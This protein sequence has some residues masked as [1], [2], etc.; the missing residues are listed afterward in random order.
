VP[1]ASDSWMEA[2]VGMR[3]TDRGTRTFLTRGHGLEGLQKCGQFDAVRR[4]GAL[5]VRPH[6]IALYISMSV[7]G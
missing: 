2:V 6:P 5:D 3:N 1:A 7:N 4:G